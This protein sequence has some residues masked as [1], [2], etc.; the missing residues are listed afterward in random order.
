MLLYDMR[1][2]M[3]DMEEFIAKHAGA[4]LTP[5]QCGRMRCIICFIGQINYLLNVDICCLD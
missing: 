4:N 3:S 1:H 5:C 2:P